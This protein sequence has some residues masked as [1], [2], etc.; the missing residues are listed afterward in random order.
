MKKVIVLALVA[1][2]CF[3]M[4][5]AC[6]KTEEPA[7]TSAAE[8]SEASAGAENTGGGEAA[9]LKVICLLNG[10][11]GDKSFFDSANKG[12]ERLKSE[13]GVDT[14]VVEMG[15]DNTKWEPALLE[16]SEQDWDVIVV[17][18]Y[19]M[20]ELLQKVAPQYPDKK[21]IIF[22]SEVDYS[23]GDC[24]NVYSITFKQNDGAYLAGIVAAGLTSSGAENANDKKIIS[25]VCGMDIPVI[26]DF[27]VGYIQGATET[28]PD[29]KVALSYV[30]DFND[31]AKAKEM[32]MSQF[33]MGSDVGFN[34]AAQAGLGV[35][36]A[37]KEK[38][39]YAIGVDADQ[40]ATFAETDPD[41]ANLIVTSVLKNIDEALIRAI[42]MHMDGTLRY[43]EAE[44]LGIAEDAVGIAKNDV[45]MKTVP[46]DIRKKVEDAE[47]KIKS[48]DIQVKTAFDMT[49]DE[50]TAFKDAA[51]PN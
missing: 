9:G 8:T 43:G 32:A 51:A 15:F 33:N 13:L 17:G 23:K 7:Q 49:T 48:G 41:K 3:A 47:T 46:E 14:K 34:T 1:I 36:D 45:Y 16:A 25:A 22:D 29:V 42:K 19:Q 20:Q 31:T 5:A 44:A 30:G 6:G 4:F 24:G 40:S 26:N 37:A 18:T 38:K 35:I 11:L 39:V 28:D 27:A 50:L 12:M 10:N 2:M 21:Y